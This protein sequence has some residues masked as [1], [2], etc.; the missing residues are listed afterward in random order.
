ML[1]RWSAEATGGHPLG[2]LVGL[3]DQTPP[4]K[5]SMTIRLALPSAPE[6]RENPAPEGQPPPCALGSDAFLLW[7][8]GSEKSFRNVPSATI[9]Q[10]LGCLH[11]QVRSTKHRSRLLC[12]GWPLA[13][14]ASP[15]L[16][17]GSR[18]AGFLKHNS[19]SRANHKTGLFRRAL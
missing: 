15:P 1:Q 3:P 13:S 5:H 2:A 18:R 6:K 8:E 16:K 10:A 14:G 12:R 17:E 4:M 9:A 19:W 7:W 11:S